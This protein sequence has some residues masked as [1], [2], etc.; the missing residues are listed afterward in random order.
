LK[1]NLNFTSGPILKLLRQIAIPSM[2]GSLFQ[3]LF[4]LVDTFYAGKISPDSLAALAKAFPLYFIIISAG[5]GIVAGCNSLIANSLG[6]KNRIAA[7][8]YSYNSLIY[9]FFLSIFIGLIGIFFSYDILKFMGS[10][11]E[12]INLSKEYTDI[13]FLGTSIFLILTSFNAILYAQGDT[14]T[15]RNVLIVG[16]FLNIILNPIFIFGLF[17]IPA[18]GIAG[19]AI[20]TVL[21]QFGACIY[22]YYKVNKTDL[23]IRLSISNFYIRRNFFINIFNQCMPITFALFL[24]AAGSYLLLSFINIFGDNAVA[25]YGAAV[26]FEHLFSLPVIGLNTAVISIAGQNFGAKRYDRIKDVY[27]KAIIIG[28]IIMCLAGIIIYISSEQ[29]ISIFSKD[30]EVISYGSTYLKIAA[31][32]GPIYPVFFISHALFT[33]LKKT[34]LIFYSNLFRMVVL[35]FT[36]VWVILN[37]MDGHFQDIFYGLL[38]MNWVF[39][40]IMLGI[41]RGLMIKTFNE[42][43]KVFFIF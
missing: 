42:Q 5:I 28:I 29:I 24:V 19:L 36:I 43:K 17:F 23:K 12:S 10:T 15:Y 34:F 32:M 18:F 9:A 27:L 41:A 13:I 6:S 37:V 4:N 40:F 25:G 35:P 22:L 3:T 11:N 33:A 39:G 26:R 30:M 7:S 16:V 1:Q 2:T 14:K 31:F 38:A 20:S 21:I 8:I